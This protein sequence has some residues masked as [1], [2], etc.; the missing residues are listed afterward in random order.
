MQQLIPKAETDLGQRLQVLQRALLKPSVA[1][2]VEVARL[3]PFLVASWL[4]LQ[5]WLRLPQPLETQ[6]LS[7]ARKA[8]AFEAL[9]LLLLL[10]AWPERRRVAVAHQG[11]M[12]AGRY[13]PCQVA[14][15]QPVL[16]AVA[17]GRLYHRFRHF[18]QTYS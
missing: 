9:E 12:A 17:A 6:P 14:L 5:P 16:L 3:A 4:W 11:L 7:D 2:L 15:E 1:I 10:H 8:L 18:H 13:L